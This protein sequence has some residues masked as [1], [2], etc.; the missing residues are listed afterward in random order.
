MSK[1]M[2]RVASAAA[3][4]VAVA[5]GLAYAQGSGD[6]GNTGSTTSGTTGTTGTTGSTAPNSKNPPATSSYDKNYSG[7]ANNGSTYN[8]NVPSTGTQ[9]GNVT[10]P[11]GSANSTSSA[12]NGTGY[13]RNGMSGSSSNNASTSTDNSSS[14][15]TW[16]TDGSRPARTDRN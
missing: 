12:G 15:G 1:T 3:V 11:D 8:P 7:G 2:I 4:C 14:S 10:S 16:N 13:G 9:P 5:G 6:T